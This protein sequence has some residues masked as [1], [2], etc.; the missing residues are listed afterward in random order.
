MLTGTFISLYE[1]DL[2]KL[3][4]EITAYENAGDIWKV[5]PGINNSAGNLVLHCCGNLQHFIGAV[6]GNSGYVRNRDLEFSNKDVPVEE[7]LQLIGN[8]RRVVLTTIAALTQEDLEKEFPLVMFNTRMPTGEV[9]IYLIS[10][11]NY[12]LGQ[13]NYHR[14]ILG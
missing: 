6:L 12:H 5:V 11:L 13:V 4:E 1:R 3:E 14:R 10:H 7:L 8:T 9:L 2:S